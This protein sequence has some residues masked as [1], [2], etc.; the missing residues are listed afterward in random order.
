MYTIK[1]MEFGSGLNIKQHMLKEVKKYHKTSEN[2]HLHYFID[3]NE[4]ANG[5]YKDYYPDGDLATIEIFFKGLSSGIMI[6]F[7][8]K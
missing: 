8:Y 4:F 2:I 5:I 1:R 6:E 7:H 3:E